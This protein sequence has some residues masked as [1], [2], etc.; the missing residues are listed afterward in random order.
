VKQF[1]FIELYEI[2][3]NSVCGKNTEFLNVKCVVPIVTT[4]LSVNTYPLL[5]IRVINIAPELSICH[6]PTQ[7]M[8]VRF[9]HY[10][11][12]GLQ[13]GTPSVTVFCPQK[14]CFS[15]YFVKT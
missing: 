7:F 9:M 14:N 1:V 2:Y 5:I 13:T 10:Y 4:L 15:L 6:K 8:K 3:K 11:T 12:F